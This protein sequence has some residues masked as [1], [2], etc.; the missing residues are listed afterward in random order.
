MK[1]PVPSYVEK[2]LA[3]PPLPRKTGTHMN[4]TL[5]LQ[6]LCFIHEE[7]HLRRI[8][9]HQLQEF[10]SG[11]TEAVHLL[12]GH[13]RRDLHRAANGGRTRRERRKP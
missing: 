8:C 2:A 11:K 10:G 3:D 5:Y 6:A 7:L 4:V 9:I 13:L 1:T 12:V